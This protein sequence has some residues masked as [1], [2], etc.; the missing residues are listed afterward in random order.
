[1]PTVV[2]KTIAQTS[3]PTTPD[4]TDLQSWEDDLPADLVSA[5]EQ[6]V[7]QCLDQGEITSATTGYMLVIA[8]ETT[9][10]TRNI[11]LTAASGASFIDNANVR[12]NALLYNA[13]NG[14]GIRKTGAYN[15]LIDVQVADVVISRLQ[16]KTD[17]KASAVDVSAGG[18]GTQTLDSCILQAVNPSDW[19]VLAFDNGCKLIN[20]VVVTDAN[21]FDGVR[22]RYGELYG[23]TIIC[24]G[25]SSSVAGIRADYSTCTITNT[26]VFGFNSFNTGSATFSGDYNATDN[27]SAQ[28]GNSVTSLTFANQFENS[29]T[30]FRAK[31]TG[32][33]QAGTPDATNTPDDITG[34]TRDATTPWI[35][36]WEVGP[37]FTLTPDADG[38]NDS[39]TDS[40]TDGA[41]FDDC[42]DDPDSSSTDWVQSAASHGPGSTTSELWL[43]LSN[44][45]ADFSSI[46]SLTLR[47]DGIING[48]VSNDTLTVTAQVFDS[49]SGG[50]ENALTDAQTILTEADTTRVQRNVSFGSLT[51]NESQWNAAHIKLLATYTRT[52]SDDGFAGRIF[53]TLFNGTY[54]ASAATPVSVTS[55]LG[56]GVGAG[57]A[58]TASVGAVFSPAEQSGQ[59]AG[60]QA[61]LTAGRSISADLGAGVGAGIAPAV[62]Q[63]Q[64][65]TAGEHSGQ[66]VGLQPTVVTGAAVPV[67]L[68]AGLGRAQAN[69]LPAVLTV[70]TAVML[71]SDLKAGTA[72]RLAATMAHG[73]VAAAASRSAASGRL[74]ALLTAGTPVTLAA[75]LQ[76]AT[77][78]RLAATLTRGRVAAAGSRPAAADRLP[79]TVTVGATIPVSLTAGLHAAAGGRLSALLASGRTL[80]PGMCRAAG[81]RLTAVLTAGQPVLL[82]AGLRS[83]AAG[84]LPA[85]LTTGA[86]VL[87]TAGLRGAAGDRLTVALTRG[88]VLAPS[89]S[90]RPGT[91]DRL[92]PQLTIAP[93]TQRFRNLRPLFVDRPFQGEG[94]S[95]YA[96]PFATQAAAE[97]GHVAY[98]RLRLI[99]KPKKYGRRTRGPRGRW[100]KGHGGVHDVVSGISKT[101]RRASATSPVSQIVWPIDAAFASQHVLWDVRRWKDDVENLST[102]F[103]TLL[104]PLDGN[105]DLVTEIL[106]TAT[107]LD[108]QLRAGGTARIRWVWKPSRDGLQPNQFTIVA[109]AGPTSPADQTRPY[110]RGRI[111]AID[112]PG[113]QD[114]GSYTYKVTAANGA[115][116]RD[117]LTGIQFTADDSGPPAAIFGSAVPV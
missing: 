36:C 31:S 54:T 39:W 19:A 102:D 67:S 82:A 86:A 81:D 16:I 111:V 93:R 8:G 89:P 115:T 95:L 106:G 35:G 30:D 113:L 116:T 27:A 53:G 99:A 18:N 101:A 62:A 88:H 6:H 22:V 4:Y 12:T 61:N 70:G 91:G 28:G 29:S 37:P 109:T 84:R 68:T 26:A 85:G 2:T 76:A 33:L 100:I 94:V 87:V 49:D 96:T 98:R 64:S 72:G 3:T 117:V 23:C 108:V 83:A 15:A 32:D 104:T 79:A 58:Q 75:R 57:L 80:T 110:S 60:L 97:A 105:R 107:L 66:G 17:T 38:T 56:S 52:G 55:G 41:L 34:F 25:G 59:G 78:G 47:I 65:H 9:D 103:R 44:V 7:G 46:E 63:G 20:T 77:A 90:P 48:T 92:A 40:D 112:T 1:M 10:A 69:R 5:D 14:I 114:G 42:N 51:G 73:Q 24:T 21:S 11:V 45:P 43:S 13:S 74:P 71:A 50:T